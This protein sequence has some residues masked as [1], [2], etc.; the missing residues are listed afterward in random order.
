M[1]FLHTTGFI[2][3]QRS[4]IFHQ[5]EEISHRSAAQTLDNLPI[6]QVPFHAGARGNELKGRLRGS[7]K[8]FM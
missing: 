4:L 2:L 5:L 1:K 3:V 8:L 7:F 6:G